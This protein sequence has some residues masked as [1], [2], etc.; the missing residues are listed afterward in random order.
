[1]TRRI[2]SL[3]AGLLLCG[4]SCVAKTAST[5]KGDVAA[6]KA[7]GDIGALKGRDATAAGYSSKA[8][9]VDAGPIS[10]ENVTTIVMQG[11]RDSA[12]SLLLALICCAAGLVALWW[13]RRRLT[14]DL[15]M[16]IHSVESCD[17]CKHAIAKAA[18]KNTAFHK[19]V[20]R[21]TVRSRPFLSSII[22]REPLP[23]PA[24]PP[25]DRV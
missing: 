15:S 14:K 10:G 4:I 21:E 7:G 23:T 13:S 3:I 8:S 22:N 5:D 2:F 16:M 25:A 20:K 24:P 6:V 12:G 1:M 9:G 18:V 11:A 17:D 19:R